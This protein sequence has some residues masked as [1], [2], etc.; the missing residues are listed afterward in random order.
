MAVTATMK[1]ESVNTVMLRSFEIFLKETITFRG[2]MFVAG[3]KGEPL[4]KAT[5]LSENRFQVNTPMHGGMQATQDLFCMLSPTHTNTTLS[6]ARH[7]DITY[8]LIVKAHLGVGMPLVIELPVIV[9]N[10]QR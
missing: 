9:S 3:K 7:V 5:I 1:S 6:A 10:W 4:T 2:Q 8:V